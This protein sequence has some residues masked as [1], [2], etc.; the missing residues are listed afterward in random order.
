M[1]H[2]SFMDE[3]DLMVLTEHEWLTLLVEGR[4]IIFE[5]G[6]EYCGDAFK[7]GMTGRLLYKNC[8]GIIGL[9]I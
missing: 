7:T 8:C 4:K 6:E 5:N 2:T 3:K 9:G 1:S